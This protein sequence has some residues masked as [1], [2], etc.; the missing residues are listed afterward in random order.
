MPTCPYKGCGREFATDVALRMHNLRKHKKMGSGYGDMKK[1]SPVW[2]KLKGKRRKQ[3]SVSLEEA[4]QALIVKR[5]MLTE[6]IEDL[7]RLS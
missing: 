5:D 7:R 1:G 2:S 6:I 4:V 3:P